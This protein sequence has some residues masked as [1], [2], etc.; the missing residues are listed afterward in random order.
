MSKRTAA[1]MQE[2][3]KQQIDEAEQIKGSQQ[4]TVCRAM[5]DPTA[6]CLFQVQEHI[7]KHFEID[8][9]PDN[10]AD[11]DE[12]F[13]PR[14]KAATGATAGTKRD[15]VQSTGAGDRIREKSGGIVGK[16]IRIPTGGGMVRNIKGKQTPIKFVTIRVPSIMSD[17]AICL[18]INTCF[19][20][21]TKKPSYFKKAA[22]GRVEINSAF[23]D[24]A[25][26]PNKKNE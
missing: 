7:I 19:K 24:K 5:V 20:Q 3:A 10:L 14:K 17:I 22:G 21:T 16:A 13:R 12:M 9:V 15:T 25:K 2:A 8:P 18:W 23:S 26:L 6:Y 4:L 11:S 1:Q